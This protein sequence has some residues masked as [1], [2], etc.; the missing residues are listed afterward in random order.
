MSKPVFIGIDIATENLRAVVI[1]ELGIALASSNHPL[2]PVLSGAGNSK[3]QDFSSWIT[4]IDSV[5]REISNKCKQLDLIPQSLSISATSGTFLLTDSKLIPI[6]PAAMYNDGR[7]STVLGRAEAI[8]NSVN[9]SGPF[10]LLNTPEFVIAHL[11]QQPANQIPTDSSHSLK[12]GIDLTTLS[13]SKDGVSNAD[14]LNIKLPKIVAPGTQIATISKDIAQSLGINQLPIYASLTDGCTAQISAGGATGSVTSLGTTMV[15]KAVSK[16]DIKGGGYYCHLL[17]A[18]RFLAGGASN[19][20]GI[21][22]KKYAPDINNWSQKAAQFG[23]ANI[24]TYPLPSIGERFP[25]ASAQM[26]NLISAEPK[27][28]VELLRAIFEAIA[29]AERYSYEI[30][31]KAGAN[32]SPAIYTTGGGGKSILLNQIRAT[33]LNKPVITLKNSGSDIG[34]AM[35]A[36]ASHKILTGD[37]KDLD[38]AAVLEKIQISHDATFNPEP[39]EKDAL[40]VNYQNFLNLTA[41]YR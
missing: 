1:D 5:L 38:L 20:G 17:P 11:A 14:R 7:G 25:F 18:N 6:A 37:V 34:A 26:P 22:Y 19:I 23:P 31:A 9:N 2:A 12:I 29:F 41:S 32:I 16:T 35:V 33:V 27:N 24:V 21:S 13:W 36:L 30:L 28:E 15:I 3:T 40:A 10:Y 39:S 4:A 8:I